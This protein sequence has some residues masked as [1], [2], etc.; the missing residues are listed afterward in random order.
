MCLPRP[1]G[2]VEDV[3]ATKTHL[4]QANVISMEQSKAIIKRNR[5][6]EPSEGKDDKSKED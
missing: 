3:T 6:V 5:I 1:R 2:V 4:M